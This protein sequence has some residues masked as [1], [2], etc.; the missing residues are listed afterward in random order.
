MSNFKTKIL[1]ADD[2]E[3]ICY[4]HW[5]HNPDI[6]LKGVVQ[7]SHGIGEY[8]G[9]YDHFAHKLQLEG[10]E[11]YANDHRAHGKTA[12]LKGLFGFYDGDDYFEDCANDM[13]SLA[14][15][16][17]QEHPKAKFILFGHSMGSLLSRTFVAKYPQKPDALI[18]SGTASFIKGLGNFGLIATRITTKVKGRGRKND[19]L[20]SIFF[21]E[22][23]KKFKPNR[24]KFDWLSTDKKEVDI[25]IED[26]YRVE[27]L[28]LGIF[29]DVI[30][31]TKKLGKKESIECIPKKLPILFFSGDEDPVGEMGKGVKKI[32][33]KYKKQGI[34]DITLNLYEG[35][36]HEMLKETNSEQ[37]END[38]LRWIE[39]RI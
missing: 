32:Y 28:S 23:N 11:I 22:F 18:L 15:I 20:K 8:A 9:R 13:H 33:K 34:E 1:T 17:R 5:K 2:G 10:Y 12:E 3:N 6:P 4:Y 27:D 35:G 19:T 29:Q 36:R 7:I 26:P 25:F 31:N 38:I 37:V 39:S 21:G 16:M 30:K 14:N 24:T